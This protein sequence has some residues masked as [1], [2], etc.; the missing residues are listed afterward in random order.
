MPFLYGDSTPS[1]L[2][3]N[4]IDFL[5]D[6]LDFAAQVLGADDAAAW[7]LG[8]GRRAAAG[9]EID[10]ARLESF[11]DA[12]SRAVVVAMSAPGVA[13]SAITPCAQSVMR[14]SAELVGAA[15]DRVRRT[16]KPRSPGSPR[17]PSAIAGAPCRRSGRCC[18]ATIFPT[19]RP[20]SA[21]C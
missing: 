6:A 14:S 13:E 15:I 5:R 16:P 4:Y 19:R 9:A 18:F 3:I 7:G 2:E 1:T 8:P 12:V 10:V 20:R 21:S 11:G 17:R